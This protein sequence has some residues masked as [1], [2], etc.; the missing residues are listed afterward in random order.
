M[1][2]ALPLLMVA[3]TAVSAI[4][5]VQ[6]GMAQADVANYRSQ[7]ALNNAQIAAQNART[8]G[9]IGE[10]EA[11]TSQLKTAGLRGQQK[12]GFAAGG[13]DVNQGSPVDVGSS[14]A[15]LGA[16]DALTIRN[17][18]AR[19]A[20]GY[21]TTAQSDRA[22]STL[23]KAEAGND[24]TS[25][26]LGAGKSL[27]GGASSLNKDFGWFGGSGGGSGGAGGT[28]GTTSANSPF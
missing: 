21:E 27:L 17:N 23:D 2:V 24:I 11:T 7:I 8:A 13:F 3:S 4:G 9:E 22:Q 19:Q 18:A 25:G 12:A 28:M 16:L 15:A 26:W 20:L 10:R 1:A 6:Q 14:T 5:S